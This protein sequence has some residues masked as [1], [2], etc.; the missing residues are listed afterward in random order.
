[1]FTHH[2]ITLTLEL[3]REQR[4][5]IHHWIAQERIAQQLTQTGHRSQSSKWWQAGRLR[6]RMTKSQSPNLSQPSAQAV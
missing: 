2:S 3:S 1:M 4:K 6:Q 5:A